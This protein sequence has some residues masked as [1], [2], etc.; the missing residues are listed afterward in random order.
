MS[1]ERARR[2]GQAIQEELGRL[3]IKGLKDPRIG[4]L[5]IT[6][7]KMTPD[8]RSGTVF[9]SVLGDEAA[10]RETAAGLRAA[11]GFLR[12]EV[13]RALSLRHTPELLFVYDESIERGARIEELLQ[14]V[15]KQG[16][17]PAGDGDGDGDEGDGSDRG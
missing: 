17:P 7:V 13:G 8:L 9:Y 4:F 5:T 11:G 6:G 3:F 15:K 10:R 16:E 1:N 2:V 12:R 14:E